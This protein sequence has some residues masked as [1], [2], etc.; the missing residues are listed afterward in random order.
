MIR[1]VVQSRQCPPWDL[2]TWKSALFLPILRKAIS[3]RDCFAC[4][5]IAASWFITACRMTAAWR[6]A[7][8]WRPRIAP[9]ALAPVADYLCFNLSCPNTRDGR[10][11]FADRGRLRELLARLDEAALSRPIFLKVAPF[12]GVAELEDFLACAGAARTVSGFAVNLPPGKPAGM[13]TPAEVLA[14]MPGAVS[15]QPCRASTEATGREL[16]RRMDRKR[17]KLIL[18]GGVFNGD[19]AYRKICLGASLV[20]V[21][22]GLVYG[23]PGAVAAINRRL[24]E[25]LARDGF[26][27]VEDAV[28]CEA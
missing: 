19:D 1:A 2:V 9:V 6:S 25:L 13:I 5:R 22:T 23:G 14:R 20:Q 3:R 28:G 21:L 16:Y 7:P 11:F 18:A 10:G 27:R 4:P 17:F 26:T 8:V 15:G 12:Q 24:A